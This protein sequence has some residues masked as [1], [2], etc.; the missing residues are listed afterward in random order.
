MNIGLMARRFLTTVAIGAGVM[1]PVVAGAA[2]NEQYFPLIGWRTGPLTPL[3]VNVAAGWIDYMDLLNKRD[4]GING[5]KLAW[6]ECETGYK[7][8]RGVECY[9]RLKN[10]G[11][12]GAS[13]FNPIN[14]GVAYALLDRVATDKI[15][16]VTIG[17]GRTDAT[18]GSVFPYV[19]PLGTNSLSTNTIKI[20][21]IGQQEG[22]MDKL[23]GK[24][25]VNLHMDSAG[26]K[27][28]IPL[29]DAQ[30][31]KYGFEITHI[32]VTMP[33]SD[34][35]SVWLEIRRV[36]PDWVILREW[37]VAPAVALK[38]A[39]KVGFPRDR[40][41]G[42]FASGTED[43]L[44]PAGASAKGY[45]V[46]HPIPTG[47]HYSVNQEI[48]ARLYSG[49]NRGNLEDQS[50]FGLV[51][52]N[53]GVTYGVINTEAVRVA[54]K[55]FG[56]KPLTGEQVRWGLENINLDEKRLKELGVSGLVQPI[57]SSCSDHEGGGSAKVFQ[58]DG[59]KLVQVSDWIHGDKALIRPLIEA[60]AAKY[61]TEKG[62]TP[63]D[64][65]KEK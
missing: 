35:Q 43:D 13:T 50:R 55:K 18:V 34:Q 25:I 36:K 62:I 2:P 61:A 63:R 17:M 39:E 45:Y 65:S 20:I 26:G 38:T 8:D 46:V 49:G 19:F 16:M 57:K 47:S 40:I 1:M 27:E 4:G 28:T 21:F 9:E 24:K 23:K 32:A 59:T 41:V 58:W 14:T 30:A 22:G 60:S 31:K 29:L 64:C 37:G 3:G 53:M 11:L 7:V 6:E 51:F 33:G 12:T 54:Q 44:I 56:N 52:Y 48:K 15:P 42:M 10:N 5:V